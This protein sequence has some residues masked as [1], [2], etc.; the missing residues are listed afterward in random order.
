MHIPPHIAY[1]INLSKCPPFRGDNEIGFAFSHANPTIEGGI[2]IEAVEID[3]GWT[4]RP[5][6]VGYVVEK[7]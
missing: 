6:T 1:E 2:M 5:Q 3:V 7:K 4:G